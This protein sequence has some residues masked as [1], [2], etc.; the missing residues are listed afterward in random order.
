MGDAKGRDR[1]IHEAKIASALN[2]PNIVT[3]YELEHADHFDFIVMEYLQG[4][5][6]DRLT[7]LRALPIPKALRYAFQIVGA[8]A[9]THGASIIHGDLKPSNIMVTD[10]GRVKLLDFGLAKA[11]AAGNHKLTQST[12][13]D[14]FVTRDYI[15]PEAVAPEPRFSS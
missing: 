5:T 14:H 8:L 15:A 6:L 9:A 2:H 10:D 1:L 7:P 3:V 4:N 11:L 13:S 12:G